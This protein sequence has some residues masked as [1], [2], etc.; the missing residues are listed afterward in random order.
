MPRLIVILVLL[1]ASADAA[2][3]ADSPPSADQQA[4]IA[5][6]AGAEAQIAPLLKAT[7][8]YAREIA[9]LGPSGQ[10]MAV[11]NVLTG[12]RRTALGNVFR[13]FKALRPD[14]E[15][16]QGDLQVLTVVVNVCKAGQLTP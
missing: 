13:D 2:L 5:S 14:L 11:P 9:S 12:A 4:E 7:E 8:D 6:C 3:A 15:Q 10:D 1:L 16:L